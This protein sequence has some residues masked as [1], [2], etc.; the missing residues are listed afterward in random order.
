MS[1]R[2]F[3]L[4]MLIKLKLEFQIKS[5]TA[6]K[7]KIS[8]VQMPNIPIGELQSEEE[9]WIDWGLALHPFQIYRKQERHR[10]R[11]SIKT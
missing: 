11:L 6:K 2:H 1:T 8:Q 5:G 10:H 7:L 9:Y 4:I 3:I